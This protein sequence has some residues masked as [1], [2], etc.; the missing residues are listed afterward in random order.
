MKK[1]YLM[2]PYSAPSPYVRECRVLLADKVAAALMQQGHIVYSPLSHSHRV[3]HHLENHLSHD[4]WLRQC[5]PF[6]EWADEA[7]VIMAAGWNLSA[8]IKLELEWLADMGKPFKYID[9]EDL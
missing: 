9:P 1:I 2:C 7:R 5:R 8:G 3:A 6:V 4:F